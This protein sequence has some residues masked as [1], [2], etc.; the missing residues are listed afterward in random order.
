MRLKDLRPGDQIRPTLD[1]ECLHPHETRIVRKGRAGL[2]VLC[3]EG[4]HFLGGQVGEY[5]QL[6]NLRRA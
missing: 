4:K 3:R 6:M 1:W 5:G 2:Y